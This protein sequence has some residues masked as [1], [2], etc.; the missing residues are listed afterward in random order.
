M[1][2]TV[3][4]IYIFKRIPPDGAKSVPSL[5]CYLNGA[6]WTTVTVFDS[7]LE[8]LMKCAFPCALIQNYYS[9]YLVNT[10]L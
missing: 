4:N 7:H 3:S 8:F 5:L 1:L 2:M 9:S 10:H 6:K